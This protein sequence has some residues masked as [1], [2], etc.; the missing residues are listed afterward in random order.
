MEAEL[1]Q[2]VYEFITDVSSYPAYAPSRSTE[3]HL[4]MLYQCWYMKLW[5]IPCKTASEYKPPNFL[6][7]LFSR[8]MPVETAPPPPS[9]L[10]Y[11]SYAPANKYS[12][13]SESRSL[14]QTAI[15]FTPSSNIILDHVYHPQF[16][17]FRLTIGTL[18]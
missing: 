16:L 15:V 3:I 11:A 18:S 5:V 12:L 1:Y 13:C 8:K 9:Q 7:A 6:G 17:Y 10:F 4:Y 2:L 14:A